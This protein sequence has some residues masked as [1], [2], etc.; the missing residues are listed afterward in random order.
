HTHTPIHTLKETQTHS[1]ICS[2]THTRI[3]HYYMIKH[4]YT[5]TYTHTHTHTHTH[6]NTHTH[7]HSFIWN[8]TLLPNLL[9]TQP[10]PTHT[11]HSPFLWQAFRRCEEGL[12]GTPPSLAPELPRRE[13]P[14]GLPFCS[15][16]ASLAGGPLASPRP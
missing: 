9:L 10:P 14:S 4:S 15:S 5:N 12:K 3:H 6:T 2:H 8:P 1:H 16:R 13:R 11:R 7:T